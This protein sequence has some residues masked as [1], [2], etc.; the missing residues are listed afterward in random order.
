MSSTGERFI[1]ALREA[2]DTHSADPLLGIFDER[3]ELWSVARPTVQRGTDG[4]RQFWTDYLDAFES[5]RSE[6]TNVVAADQHVALEWR[7]E[8]RLPDGKPLT[9]NGV[10]LLDLDGD[11]IVRFRTY[12]D[13]RPFLGEE[14]RRS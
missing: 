12:Y 1:A 9:Y 10:S 2:E 3:A 7:S 4:A 11:R 8:G 14:G 6:F 5:V 13:P